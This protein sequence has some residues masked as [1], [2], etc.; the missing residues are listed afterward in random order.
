MR[1]APSAYHAPM[2]E[3][4]PRLSPLLTDLYELTMAYG[5]WKLGRADQ[6]AV[7]HLEFRDR[8]F[9]GGYAIACG[10][11]R[12]AEFIENYHFADE[13]LAYLATVRAPDG[14]ELFEP[15]FLEYLRGLR[16]RCDVDAVAEGT[17]VFPHEPVLR[18]TGPILQAQVLETAMLTLVGFETLIATKA[19]RV[20]HAAAG[21]PVIEFGLRRAQGADGGLSA[22]RA[23][24]VGGCAGTSNVL[25]GQRF[26]IP[27][28]GTHAHSWVQSFPTEAASFDA[29]ARVMPH[30]SIF[31]VDTYQTLLG[32]KQAAAV[33]QAMARQGR[34]MAGIRLDSGDLAYLSK[35]A[36]R[37]LDDHGLDDAK[38]LA[39][40]DLDEHVIESLKLQ[41]ARID[42]WGVGTRLTTAYDQP[43]LG[44][45][46]KLSAVRE[47]DR[48][49]PSLKLSEQ[50]AKI[51]TPGLLRVRRYQRDGEF[52]ADAIYDE[53]IGLDNPTVIVDPADPMRRRSVADATGGHEL[54]EPLFRAG[55]R[56]A[57]PRSIDQARDRC[58]AQLEALHDGVKR[59]LN[60]HTYPVGLER[61][62]YEL[63]LK[64]VLRA[65][66][67][68]ETS[69]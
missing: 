55:R 53:Q 34:R 2:S 18:V 47:G 41:D 49:R 67:Q 50:A 52:I 16:L 30:N 21:D 39:S 68:E 13:D 59:L 10:L 48:W 61:R 15:A 20:C 29:W 65:R 27:I 51:S 25:A 42:L 54:L 43:A 1:P 38:I 3:P 69:P 64:L 32:V 9:Q 63:K 24:Y 14:A 57:A 62:L 7:F 6:P 19:A 36:R 58:R 5:Y 40:G 56:V 17:A 28:R 8:P 60:P 44:G 33:G 66:G 35:Q 31:L 46:Y 26:G 45:V 23:A 37:I 22:A 4:G 11:A 12:A